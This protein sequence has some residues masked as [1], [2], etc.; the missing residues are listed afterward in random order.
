MLRRN[1]VRF[2]AQQ[3]VFEVLERSCAKVLEL[4]TQNAPSHCVFNTWTPSSVEVEQLPVLSQ[5]S[6][7]CKLAI[8]HLGPISESTRTES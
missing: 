5:K 3:S 6:T 8:D 1:Q 4:A 7:C 2:E